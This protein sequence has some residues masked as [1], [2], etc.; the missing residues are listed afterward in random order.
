MHSARQKEFHARQDF[1]PKW[2]EGESFKEFDRWIIF[3]FV[4]LRYLSGKLI[5]GCPRVGTC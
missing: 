1:D 3:L 5:N 4:C 2:I